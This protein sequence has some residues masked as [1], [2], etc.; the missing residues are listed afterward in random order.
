MTV[1][2]SHSRVGD[3]SA[4]SCWW[5]NSV[6]I[7]EVDT[8]ALQ[9]QNFWW[10]CLSHRLQ[11]NV[12]SK[13]LAGDCGGRGMQTKA[14]KNLE[15]ISRHLNDTSAKL[16]RTLPCP[17]ASGVS[18]KGLMLI[19]RHAPKKGRRRALLMERAGFLEPRF[20]TPPKVMGA[21]DGTGMGGGLSC[22]SMFWNQR[23]RIGS[24][25]LHQISV[26]ISFTAATVAL[27]AFHV[28]HLHSP[29][30]AQVHQQ[31]LVWGRGKC[32]WPLRTKVI[33]F[34]TSKNL[35]EREEAIKPF[36]CPTISSHQPCLLQP[37]SGY[38]LN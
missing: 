38:S 1:I 28:I 26:L 17:F 6:I 29:L 32:S 20:L 16:P 21:E 31:K 33:N 35:S 10:N 34:T 13:I 2:S 27:G 24:D 36:S 12:C 19:H 15:P 4:P 37:N 14:R 8:R 5:D 18:A 7:H 11:A 23:L 25:R 22:I 3:V 9:G 30:P